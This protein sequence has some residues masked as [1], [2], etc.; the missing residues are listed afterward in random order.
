M[1]ANLA[2]PFDQDVSKNDLIK[3]DYNLMPNNYSDSTNGMFN[4][5]DREERNKDSI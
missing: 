3:N 5:F 4:L 2:L 1:S